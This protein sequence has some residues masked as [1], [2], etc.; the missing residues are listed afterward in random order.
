MGDL[1]EDIR[2]HASITPNAAAIRH[3]EV[4]LSYGTLSFEAD[5]V[6]RYLRSKQVRSG[7]AVALCY[8]RS[9][10]QIVAALGVLRAGGAYVPLDP[11][12]P[13]DR[14]AGILKD[15]G[16]KAVMAPAEMAEL[17]AGTTFCVSMEDLRGLEAGTSEVSEALPRESLAYIIYTSGSTGMPKGVEITHG[18]LA[19][20]IAWH[21]EAFG[22]T[23]ADCASHVAGLGFDASVWEVWPYLAAGACVSLVDEAARTSPELLQQ[24]LVEDGITIAFVPTP[25][26]EPMIMMDWPR[27]TALRF[28]LTG[29]DTLH[30]GPKADLPFVTVNNYGPT[31]CTVVATSGVVC[32]GVTGLPGIGR[33]IRGAEVYVVGEDGQEVAAGG[34]GELCIGGDGVGRG[35]RGQPEQTAR[36]FA[37]DPKTGGMIYRTGDFGRLLPDGEIAFCGREDGQVKIRGQR[38]EMDEIVCALDRH[39]GVAFSAVGICGEGEGK[40]LVAYVLP[41]EEAEPAVREMQEFLRQS[42]PGSMIPAKFVRLLD[43]PLS[44]NGKVDRSALPEPSVEN[45][46]AE[47]PSRGP[48]SQ[49]EEAILRIIRTLLKIDD[50]GVDDDFF[51]I[52]GHSLMGTRLVLRIRE[53]FGVKISLQ[54]LFE[55]GTVALLAEQ[56]EALLIQELHLMS[57]E[58]AASQVLD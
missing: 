41:V 12:W 47:T 21:R 36:A 43:L 35:Y 24:W 26:A 44:A 56:V 53:T 42:L 38:V 2:Q 48:T 5:R 54:D 39:P 28:L 16:A 14:I 31:E 57:E 19:H 18:N 22:V 37:E 49:V 8:P 52:G 33:A 13:R 27:E 23:A 6:A 1:S 29:G 34:M 30:H 46:F 9:F 51:L 11:S 3:A 25:L 45:G 15:V 55:A 20:L 17:V 4:S 32:A 50:V 7:D 58:E 40:Q 10:D